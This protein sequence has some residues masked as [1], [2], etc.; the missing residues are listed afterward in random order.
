MTSELQ[1]RSMADQ[2]YEILMRKILAGEYAPGDRIIESRVAREHGISQAPVREALRQLDAV[3]LIS[4]VPHRGAVV[5]TVATDELEVLVPVRAKLEGV[6]ARLS[7]IVLSGDIAPLRVHVDGMVAAAEDLD[8]EKHYHE[9][10]EFHRAIAISTKNE[11]VLWLFDC[12]AFQARL[13]F[14][15]N[16]PT[17]MSREEMLANAEFHGQLAE[18][19][20]AGDPDQA[21]QAM[22]EHCLSYA[23]T[24]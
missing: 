21:E 14:S 7:T 23:K 10:F 3:G 16:I 22:F 8:H 2:M 4:S 1:Y 18:L 15:L 24:D 13:Q 19:I 20:E 6:A 17:S 11:Q 5:R 9:S 12:M